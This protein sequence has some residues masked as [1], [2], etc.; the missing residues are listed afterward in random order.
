MPDD[1]VPTDS[2]V[3]LRLFDI[4]RRAGVPLDK[5]VSVGSETEWIGRV[6]F[7]LKGEPSKLIE[8]LSFTYHAMFLDR[9]EDEQRFQR[10]ERAGFSVLRIWDTD[11]WNHPNEVAAALIDFSMGLS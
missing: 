11:V 8:L 7:R 3:E 9:L 4:G 2:G 1:Y 5:Q 6:D 10:M